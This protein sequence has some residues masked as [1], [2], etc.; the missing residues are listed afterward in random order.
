MARDVVSWEPFR[1]LSEFR[2]RMDN[3]FEPFFGRE[4]GGRWCVDVDV[5]ETPEEIQVKADVPGID[6][7]DISITLSGDNLI[8]LP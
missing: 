8:S 5:T 2:S 3:L 6:K 7:K 1:E 4:R